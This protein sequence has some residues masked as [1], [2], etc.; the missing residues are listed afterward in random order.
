MSRT[1]SWGQVRP[2]HRCPIAGSGGK[3]V[4]EGAEAG[5]GERLALRT[6]GIRQASRRTCAPS[7]T[8]RAT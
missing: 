5:G 2:L 3:V 6:G 7:K 8:H 1:T 4:V